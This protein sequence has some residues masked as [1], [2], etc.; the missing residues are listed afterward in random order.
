[1]PSAT[2]LEWIG[3]YAAIFSALV[4]ASVGI[5]QFRRG[6]SQSVRELEWKQAE[7]ARTLTNAMM[8]DR[9]GRL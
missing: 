5:A 3:K 7:M 9:V 4:A 8:N 6:V 2:R 1:M